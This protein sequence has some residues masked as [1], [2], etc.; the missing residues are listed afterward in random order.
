MGKLET[1]KMRSILISGMPRSGSTFLW[2]CI[3]EIIKNDPDISL[4]RNHGGVHGKNY[5][6]VLLTYRNIFDIVKSLSLTHKM[7]IHE[8]LEQ[9]FF[10][11][12]LNQFLDDHKKGKLIVYENYLPENPN[13]LIDLVFNMIFPEKKNQTYKI[14]EKFSLEE[15]KRRASK[16]EDFSSYDR[17]DS[18]I[19]GNHIT[20]DGFGLSNSLTSEEIDI[21]LRFPRMY[22][23]IEIYKEL[24]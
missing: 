17:E 21:I 15:N 7:K 13:K 3:R 1:K 14:I 24:Y 2:Q 23:Y 11:E 5:D 16:Y 6:F 10:G 22:E 8:I 19:H 20:S 9:N 12:Y 18:M 4:D